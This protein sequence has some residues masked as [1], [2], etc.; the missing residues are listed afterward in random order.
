M[1][2]V[3][4]IG[5]GAYGGGRYLARWTLING[6]PCCPQAPL[7]LADTAAVTA[8]AAIAVNQA[9]AAIAGRA[10]TVEAAAR[11]AAAPPPA[12]TMQ[13][14]ASN[15]H[16]PPMPVP[17]PD[18][19]A[20]DAACQLL[21]EVG[22]DGALQHLLRTRQGELLRGQWGELL[23]N[24]WELS[25]APLPAFNPIS[26][27]ADWTGAAWV[28]R[29]LTVRERASWP[30]QPPPVPAVVTRTQ[31]RLVLAGMDA[32]GGSGAP[33]MLDFVDGLVAASGDRVLQERWAA[34]RMERSSTYL[35]EMATTLLGLDSDGID[36]IF[37]QAAVT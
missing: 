3:D 4:D 34:E 2:R 11:T 8:A 12:E 25:L 13:A 10:E 17:N 5:T 31:L 24:P 30:V 35:I 14:P 16:D 18:R 23:E 1:Q 27:T 32:P 21:S 26:Q 29:D 6:R 28:V 19:L 15:P 9:V 22:G 36:A 37:R 7:I 20:W 33:T